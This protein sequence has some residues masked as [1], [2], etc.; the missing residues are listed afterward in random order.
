M[1][2][3]ITTFVFRKAVLLDARV[4]LRPGKTEQLRGARLVV[5]RL[6]Q[7]LYDQ[8]AFE[9]F[10]IDAAGWKGSAV[11]VTTG[12]GGFARHRQGQM[13][14]LDVAAVGENDGPLDGV[15]QLTDVARPRIRQQL[16]LGVARD[17]CRWL[18]DGCRRSP[19]RNASASSRM[20]SRR[21]RSGGSA[22]SNTLRR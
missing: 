2:R 21:S 3:V 7:R 20:S 14:G 11:D 16:I 1:N 9:I 8:R 17:A 13:L 12:G 22:I 15:A 18:A 6:G 4:Q 19:S 5:S 10:Q